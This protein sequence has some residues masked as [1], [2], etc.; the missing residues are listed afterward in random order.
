MSN[1]YRLMCKTD[2]F[3]TKWN[4][5]IKTHTTYW[6]EEK[7]WFLF[8]WVMVGPFMEDIEIAKEYL[9]ALQSINPK[10]EEVKL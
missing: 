1:R 7:E 2:V 3:Y 8:P 9:A 10:P 5:K 4:E 6:I